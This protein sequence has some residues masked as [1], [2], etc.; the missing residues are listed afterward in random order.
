MKFDNNF[1]HTFISGDKKGL[2]IGMATMY[3]NLCGNCVVRTELTL[4]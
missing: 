3:K 1:D 4:L 2:W